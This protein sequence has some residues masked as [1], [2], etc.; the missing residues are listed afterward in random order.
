MRAR[1]YLVSGLVQ[2]VGYRAATRAAALRLG[3][4][5]WVRNLPDG[6]VEAC[7]VGDDTALAAFELWLR[8]GP[9]LSRVDRVEAAD[10]SPVDSADF[11]VR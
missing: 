5:G 4:A 7:A 11:V 2:G 10:T 6:R 1:H 3:L 8:R 9:G